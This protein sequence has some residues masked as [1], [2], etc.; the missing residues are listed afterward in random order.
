MTPAIILLKENKIEYTILEYEHNPKEYSFGDEAVE[1]LN[2]D[3]NIVFKTLILVSDESQKHII[4][5]IPVSNM[6]NIKK[7][8]KTLKLK[9]ISMMDIKK[10]ENITGYIKGAISPISQKKKGITV[11]DN[12]ACNF[13]K[14]YISGGKRGLEIGINVNDLIAICDATS[15]DL[16]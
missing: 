1:L 7:L 8:A 16:V 2:L 3:K 6:L 12:S 15:T 10:A 5:I 14:I 9:K 13:D 11:I 4:A